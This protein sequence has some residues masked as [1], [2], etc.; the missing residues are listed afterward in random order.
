MFETRQFAA[1]FLHH[2]LDEEI[3]EGDASQSLL[4]VGYRIE[5]SGPRI[6]QWNSLT[7]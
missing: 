7:T 1:Q 6:L 4:A 2:L 3:A 5:D